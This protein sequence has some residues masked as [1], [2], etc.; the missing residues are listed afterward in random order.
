MKTTA[1]NRKIRELL[2]SLRE[3]RLIPRPDFQRRLVWSNKDKSAFL[4]T[5]LL[6]YPFPEIYVAAGEVDVDTGIGTELLVDGQQ[7]VTTLQQYFNASPDLILNDNIKPYNELARDDKE[8]FL[9]YD[10]VVRDLGSVDIELVRNIFQKINATSYALN[11]MEIRNSR[12]QGEYKAF[13]E[14][15]AQDPFFDV[16]RVFSASEIRRMQDTRYALSI[17]TTILSTYFNRDDDLE[18]YLSRFND[19]FPIRDD[20]KHELSTVL[21]FIDDL[22]FP[23]TSRLWKKADLFTAIIEVHRS[24]IK[25]NLDLVPKYVALGLA[26]LYS[27]VDDAEK[28]SDPDS[29]ASKY[30][31]AALQATNDRGSRI[32]RG[33][34]V[35]KVLESTIPRKPGD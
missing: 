32:T 19:D 23:Q 1:T 29:D 28:R 2:T 31:K 14:E 20:L 9:Q 21:D 3:Q 30:Y 8:A 13:G 15:F 5:V 18:E 33:E 24:L 6:N 11:A 16:H 17:A 7:R 10:V 4:E 12:Y 27:V 35:Q 25:R 22:D 34:I 26:D